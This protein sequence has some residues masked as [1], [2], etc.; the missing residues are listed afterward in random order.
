MHTYRRLPH[1]GTHFRCST[2]QRQLERRDGA[3]RLRWPGDVTAQHHGAE[4]G[5]GV[6]W[7]VAIDEAVKKVLG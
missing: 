4:C 7:L 3:L 1:P 6:V 5:L 2:C